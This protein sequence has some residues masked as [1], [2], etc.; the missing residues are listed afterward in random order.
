M[1]GV[2]VFVA[3]SS[4]GLRIQ[5]TPRLAAIERSDE[6][7]AGVTSTS[8][9]KQEMDS[10]LQKAW[11]AVALLPW[12]LVR[13][14]H[15][16]TSRG[17]DAR[18]GSRCCGAEEARAGLVPGSTETDRGVCELANCQVGQI[19]PTE[20][21]LRE[22]TNRFRVWRPGRVGRTVRAGKRH[23][24]GAIERAQIELR[25]SGGRVSDID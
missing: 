25:A 14:P 3:D 15:G 6:H 22:E 2:D 5:E 13:Q 1:N 10:V 9:K 4:D 24:V 20:L 11:K 19:E 12:P 8:G 18:H 7:S 23:A 17:R 21:V 16:L